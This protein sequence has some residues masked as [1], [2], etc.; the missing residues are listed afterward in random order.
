ME[1]GFTKMHGAGNDFIVINDMDER[2]RLSSAGIAGL[3]SRHRGIGADGLILLRPS[4]TGSFAMRYYNSDGGEADMCGNGARCA[5]AFAHEAGVADTS[6]TFES[7]AGLVRAD[8]L[9]GGV[10]VGVGDVRGLKLGMRIGAAD[11]PVHFGVCGV[12]HAVVVLDDVR[13][14]SRE[15]FIRFARAIRRDAAFAPAGANVNIATVGGRG[16][17]VYRTYERGVEDETLACGT[18]AVVIATVLVHLGL[19]DSPVECETRGG[20]NLRVALAKT[21]DGAMGCLLTGPVA[22]SFRGTFL[23][24]DYEQP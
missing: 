10:R 7:R 15:E 24:E 13:E 20:D 12:P 16:R 21:P 6:M 2:C 1:F 22:V 17:C 8:I 4:E 14:V 3:C 18:G 5:A 23:I 9:E 19:A 11:R